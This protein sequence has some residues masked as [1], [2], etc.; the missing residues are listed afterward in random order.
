MD[1]EQLWTC[2]LYTLHAHAPGVAR[3]LRAHN[4]NG[5]GVHLRNVRAA[6]HAEAVERV[7]GVAVTVL[8]DILLV[9]GKVLAVP[10]HVC[11]LYTSPLPG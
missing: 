1:W 8:A 5:A 4:V 3:L 6:D 9:G 2:L 11:L 7:E 10:V